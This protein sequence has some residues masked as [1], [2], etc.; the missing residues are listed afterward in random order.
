MDRRGVQARSAAD[1]HRV[2]RAVLARDEFNRL[3]ERLPRSARRGVEPAPIGHVGLVVQRVSAEDCPLATVRAHVPAS[4][5]T[6]RELA[7]MEAR[8]RDLPA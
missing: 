2:V 3:L 7:R 5:D 8:L 1:G 4:C 6:T